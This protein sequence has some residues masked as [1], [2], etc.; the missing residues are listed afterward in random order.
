MVGG[1]VKDIV[2]KHFPLARTRNISNEEGLL[3]S[4]ILDSLGVLDLVTHLE[5]EFGITVSDEELIPKNFYSI[6]SLAQFIRGKSNHRE[7]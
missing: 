1:K 7:Q 3:E 5:Q 4:G 6:N 2:F